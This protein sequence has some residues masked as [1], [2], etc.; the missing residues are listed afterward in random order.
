MN[1][2]I[3]MS[4]PMRLEAESSND[5]IYRVRH[6]PGSSA[7]K[8]SRGAEMTEP[9]SVA[10]LW[11]KYHRASEIHEKACASAQGKDVPGRTG[12]G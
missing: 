3:K 10:D 9:T 7:E 8:Q 6:A 12:Y 11:D 5:P 2:T 4:L 1:I